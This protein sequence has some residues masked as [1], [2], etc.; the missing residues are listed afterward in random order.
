MPVIEVS[1]VCKRYQLHRRRQLMMQHALKT[2]RRETEDFW[3]LRDISLSVKE[4]ESVGLVGHNGAGKSTLLSLIVGVTAPTSGTIRTSG[5]IGSLLELGTGFQP[6]LTARE[7]IYLCGALL[8]FRR[9]EL[10]AR[11]DEI[12]RFSELERFLDEP[13]RTFSTGMVARLGFAIAVHRDPDIL[14]LDEVFSV[15]DQNFQKKCVTEIR[16]FRKRGKTLLFVSHQMDSVISTCDRAIWLD[17]GTMKMDGPVKE[18]A[19]AYRAAA[20]AMIDAG[21]TG[22]RAMALP[23]TRGVR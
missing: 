17:H 10:E 9:A 7:N 8:G 21:N 1:N 15:G 12:V 16:D 5:R 11:F 18:V 20:P 14:V 4:G 3:A 6:E 2:M 23:V 22:D 19:E 13:I